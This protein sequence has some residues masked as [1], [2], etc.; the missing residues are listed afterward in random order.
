MPAWL[1]PVVRVVSET[2]V[3]PTTGIAL[4]GSRVLVPSEF[5]AGDRPLY[6]LDGGA[7]L[8]Q[9]GRPAAPVSTLPLEG[10]TVLDVEGLD[11]PAVVLSDAGPGDGDVIALLAFPPADRIQAGVGAVRS[12]GAVTV[13]SSGL[14][15]LAG[16]RPLPNLTGALVNAC[17]QWLGWSAAREPA[18]MATG[19]NTVYHWLPALA[20]HLERAGAQL[21]TAPCDR[22]LAFEEPPVGG[23]TEPGPEPAPEPATE[24]V[25]TAPAAPPVAPEPEPEPEPETESDPATVPEPDP[26]T[27]PKPVE[28]EAPILNEPEPV[29]PP[30][31]DEP[32]SMDVES[33]GLADHVPVLVAVALVLLVLGVLAG[34]VWGRRGRHE[35]S[36][37]VA[38]VASVGATVVLQLSGPQGRHPIR[39]RDG[40]VDLVLGRFD[41]DLLLAGKAVSRHH[42]RL[43]GAPG[44]LRLVDLGSTNGTWRNGE[45]LVQGV[46]VPVA[47]GDHLRFGDVELQVEA[48]EEA[49]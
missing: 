17:E 25:E 12:L 20:T 9:F 35:A 5:A 19:R 41:A 33:G 38:A 10:L 22:Q 45:R 16:D 15:E 24:P 21:A 46:A 37:A 39:A 23:G 42:A 1:V 34:R 43:Q 49:P 3:V 30:G 11:R 13:D 29:N 47:P 40:R 2:H 6:V 7:D 32:S 18:S 8:R 26:E 14:P 27:E 48:P 31:A 4:G 44:D 36:E 28:A